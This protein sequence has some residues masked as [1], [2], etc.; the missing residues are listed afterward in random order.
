MS[1]HPFRSRTV[2]PSEAK[3][4]APGEDSSSSGILSGPLQG[5]GMY[6][7]AWRFGFKGSA[8]MIEAEVSSV[9][10]PPGTEQLPGG[11][12]SHDMQP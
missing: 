2:A 10:N 4:A 3:T 12:H 9:S 1:T 6:V 7:H 11:L 5:E 8:S